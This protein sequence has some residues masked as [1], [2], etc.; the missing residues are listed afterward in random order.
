MSK[1]GKK[2]NATPKPSEL[3]GKSP[4]TTEAVP[5]QVEQVAEP[6]QVAEELKVEAKVEASTLEQMVANLPDN[7][8]DKAMEELTKLRVQAERNEAT[9]A[10]V[11]FNAD[12]QDDDK[13][14]VITK[15]MVGEAMNLSDYLEAV[16]AK[17]EVNLTGRRITITYPEGKF[18]LTNSPKG[19]GGG[20]GRSGFPP[21]WGNAELR[22]KGGKV[23][24]KATSPSKLAESMGLQVEG[25]RDMKDV[26][27]NPKERGTKNDLPKRYKVEA[28]RGEYFRVV[29]T[30]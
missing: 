11:G 18:A 3:L 28:V 29:E 17:H 14:L 8:R 20:N 7:I 25:M 21:G 5:E 22:D 9:K 6:E 1:H 2:H 30:S 12:L 27:E 26:F 4:E 19:K 23:K 16:R 10:F 24:E 13:G 15:E